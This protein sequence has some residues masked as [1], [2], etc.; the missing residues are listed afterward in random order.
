MSLVQGSSYPNCRMQGRLEG[1]QHYVQGVGWDP[2][3][4]LLLTLS[5]DRT[6][7]VRVGLGATGAR[8][9]GRVKR[10]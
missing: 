6:A 9:T 1:H 3:G 5:S 4:H 10:G 2:L 8:H 7:K